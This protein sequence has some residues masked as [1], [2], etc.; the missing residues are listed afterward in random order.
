MKKLIGFIGTGVFAFVLFVNTGNISKNQGLNLNSLINLNQA[1]AECVE[2]SLNN[3]KCNQFSGHCF[4]T[5][6]PED[7]KCDTYRS[8]W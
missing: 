8:T 4:L 3:G 7:Q 1:N 6:V 2:T 5:A